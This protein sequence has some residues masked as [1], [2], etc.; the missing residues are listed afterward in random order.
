VLRARLPLVLML[1][2]PLAA[3]SKEP[4]PT[5]V[6]EPPVLA[7]VEKAEKAVPTEAPEVPV[8][9]T[10]AKLA[11]AL[12]SDKAD[13]PAP[14]NVKAKAPPPGAAKAAKE[15]A[16][17]TG[18]DG[19]L[20]AGAADKVLP[21]GG[22]P[23]IK[24]LDTGAEPR[25]DLSYAL[26]KGSTQKIQ[27]NMDMVMAMKMGP[28]ALPPTTIPTMTML[29]DMTTADKNPSGE[30]K[31]DSKLTQITIN[32]KGAQQ[33]Q[34]ASAMRPQVEGMKGL[35]MGYW[36]NGKGRV[37][38]VKIDVPKSIPAAAQQMLQ[39][40][41]QSFES[42]VAP[43]PSDAVGIGARWQVV[44]RMASSGADLLQSAVYTLK[45]RDGGKVKLDV[46]LFQ[47][48]ASETIKPPGMP[49]GVTARVKAFK[50]GGSGASQIDTKNV[51]PDSGSMALKT[52]M[53][54][55]VQGGG[56][57]EETSVETQTKVQISKP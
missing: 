5:P 2:L 10:A 7:K 23:I 38:D 6:P 12:A 26:N 42:M 27:M 20:P 4:I 9:P 46:T 44:S 37:R 56:T 39:G 3:C 33:E 29:L 32:P 43:L 55:A 22:Q 16:L 13:A 41:N 52:T 34:F 45:S 11:D 49:P 36:I 54:I 35:G 51:A 17:P 1:V 21:V 8:A 30:W 48:A 53:D 31:I 18:K 50:S 40:M 25:S 57:N 14:A 24:L 28:K 19:V 15:I 47:L